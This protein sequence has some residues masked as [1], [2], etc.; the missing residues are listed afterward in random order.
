ME[1]KTILAIILSMV[2]I[3]LWQLIFSPPAKKPVPKEEPA[4]KR[5]TEIS[6]QEGSRDEMPTRVEE[7]R[8]EVRDVM[9][10]TP[11]YRA[12]FTTEGGG[13][14]SWTLKQY[15][16]RVETVVLWRRKEAE[17]P[18][19]V[20]MVAVE[21]SDELPLA[22]DVEVEG[23]QHRNVLFEADRSELLLEER[24]EGSITF[25]GRLGGGVD[26]VKRYRFHGSEYRVDLDVEVI[27]RG[28]TSVNPEMSL[29][30]YGLVGRAS[31]YT[32]AGPSVLSGTS[33][34]RLKVKEVQ[35]GMRFTGDIKWMADEDN[36]FVSLIAPRK[37]EDVTV[38]VRERQGNG[39]VGFESRMTFSRGRV[40]PGGRV[41]SS[42]LIYVG[43][44]LPEL[45]KA[46]E[47]EGEKAINFGKYLGSIEKVLLW[48][49]ELAYHVTGN[50]G[51]AI[52][53]LSILLKVI[54]W[55]LSRRSYRSMQEMQKV[56]PEMKMLQE[57]YKDDKQRLNQE[58]MALYKRRKVNP[59]GGC[60]P[61]LVQFP[62][63]IALYKALPLAF[64]LRHAPF[65]LWLRDLSAADT[66][67]VDQLPLPL[68]GNTPVGPL[69]LLMGV[70]MLIQQKMSPTM[71]DPRQAKMMMIM[72]VM[73]IFIFLSFPSGL[74]LYWFV[75]NLLSIGEQYLT[76]RGRS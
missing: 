1:K 42:F 39:G 7:G 16:D 15:K 56:Q 69:P 35:K 17:H 44:K 57:K 63:L 62:F 59:V 5:V 14:K 11:L 6:G 2:V 75:Q 43:P 61:M 9:V 64:N 25:I 3:M 34:E 21:R 30:W 31:R 13:L 19:P 65:V 55:P 74:V 29:S 32:F 22:T 54:F 20:E 51:V 46:L 36:Y 47:V 24:D 76:R 18:E 40:T 68:L 66:F 67:F 48:F 23:T 10:E 28:A 70:S 33:V 8:G 58:M 60:L 73:F 71:G 12:I 41:E 53:I 38:D 37:M 26:I 4:E 49:L 50:Y 45:L 27:N 72:P 52:I